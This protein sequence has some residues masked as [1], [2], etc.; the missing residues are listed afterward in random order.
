MQVFT[1][2]ASE[3]ESKEDNLLLQREVENLQRKFDNV[4]NLRAADRQ[5]II[6]LERRVSEERRSRNSCESQ[7]AQER[8]SRKQEEARAAQVF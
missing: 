5:T 4:Q 8:K 6:N 2:I 1:L 7:L 3:K